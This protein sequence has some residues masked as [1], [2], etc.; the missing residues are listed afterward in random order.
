[1]KRASVSRRDVLKMTSA[2]ALLTIVP[3]HL[4]GAQGHTPP[5]ET[6]NIACVGAGGRG[7]H[8]LR[9]LKQQDVAF[10]LTALCDLDKPRME[11]KLK[12]IFP[13]C[14]DAP[15]YKDYREMLDKGGKDIDAVIVSTP[16]HTHAVITMEAMRRGKHVYTQK[17]LT[18]NI[19]EARRL[20][21]SARKHKVIS[22]MGNQVHAGRALRVGV[23]ML[24]S[25]ALGQ[26][27]EVHVI[28][29]VPCWPY[30]PRPTD[31]PKCPEHFDWD[32][33]V[34][35]AQYRPY[36]PWYHPFAWRGFW[37]FGTGALGDWGCHLL[38]HPYW[39]LDLKDPISVEAVT[40][41]ANWWEKGADY[42]GTAPT[43]SIVKWEFPKRGKLDPLTL[44][45]YDGGLKPMRP[46]ELGDSR[47][48]PDKGVMYVAEE[49]VAVASWGSVPRLI[50]EKRM[51]G[52]TFKKDLV[53][54]SPGHYKE[55]AHA[56]TGKGPKPHDDFDYAA[57]LT[58]TILLGTAA[59]RAGCGRE[60]LWDAKAM[61]ITNC[62]E[63]NALIKEPYREGWTL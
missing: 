31:T 26:V 16:D 42:S 10:N 51:K 55:W 18:H 15:F 56:C 62:P 20:K 4:L 46:A 29:K 61:R 57:G 38:D 3:R 17:P 44:Y 39:A 14:P 60:Y 13:G 11:A 37:D 45:W 19:Y 40:A 59:L 41:K 53:P 27:R 22:S 34:G 25:G 30:R 32:L 24:K 12:Q 5:S 2:A 50:P 33:W 23:S 54:M 47:T 48:L 28:A 58:E 8:D 7:A 21:E 63:A 49:G 1:M 36:H 6:L 52:F 9:G 43:A 35:P